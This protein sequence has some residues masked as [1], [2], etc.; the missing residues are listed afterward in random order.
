MKK[1][2]I[3]LAFPCNDTTHIKKAFPGNETIPWVYLGQDF[4]KRRNMAR[5][6]GDRFSHINIA[7]LHDQVAADLRI[8][9]VRWVDNLNRLHGNDIEWWFGSISS[10]NPYHNNIFQYCCYLEILERLQINDDKR[11]M[12]VVLESPG[13]ARAIMKWAD[14]KN[15][16]NDII[17]KSRLEIGFSESSIFFLRWGKFIIIAIMR[18]IA[19]YIT[20]KMFE[21]KKFKDMVV[22]LD[23][24]V[25]DYS[26]NEDGTFKDRYFPYLHEYLSKKGKTVV[27]HP[28]LV[29]FN[30]N[31][32]SIY[33]KMRKSKTNFIM[34]EDFL[35]FSD[36]LSAFI[37]PLKV[38]WQKI[39][40]PLFQGFD[41]SDIL[42]EERIENPVTP[43]LEAILI[44]RLF[45]R[46]GTS[47]LRP[48]LII[49][50]YENQV[51]D[52]AL[53]AGVRKA[54]PTVKIIGVQM[55]IHSFNLISQFPSQ[56]EAEA[57]II[58]HLL[59]ET[60]R[61]QCQR[62]K[63]F[64][65]AISCSSAA[66]LRYSHIFD[67]PEKNQAQEAKSILALLPFTIDESVEILE[68]L[69]E[70]LEVIR[71]DIRILIKGHPD[72]TSEELINSFGEKIWPD[73]F[74]IYR[75]TLSEVLNHAL[76][77]I[78]SNSSSMVEAATKG[79]PVIFLGRQTAIN[80]N[81][82]QDS[83]IDIVTECFSTSELVIAIEKY[84]NLTPTE[85]TKYKEMG[86]KLRDL[87]FTPVNEETLLPFLGIEKDR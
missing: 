4:F 38:L 13:L 80:Y 69:K 34:K 76:L 18:W 82:L 6:L 3:I 64:T 50:W 81:M 73:R 37:Y 77:V 15:I 28:V 31:Y 68:T 72:Y 27:V 85:K 16:A 1:N 78:S 60:S 44:Y 75:G 9:Y 56:S 8:S 24:F 53:I 67:E 35:H 26:L 43:A 74:E 86:K 57:N 59:L 10:R 21:S 42:K 49:D 84:L 17:H 62:V 63:S 48:E 83:K 54:F 47:G 36:Y 71:D 30:Y 7:R 33:K 14:G 52:K 65:E 20:G 58:P 32:F 23:T 46:L 51:I 45:L 40:A 5:D 87:F 70:I 39:K 55:F 41:I 61:Y 29:G 79:I 11:P 12:L 22:I 2:H 66:A 19:A 25:H